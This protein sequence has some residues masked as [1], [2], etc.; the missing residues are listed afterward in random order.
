MKGT[1]KTSRLLL[2]PYRTTDIDLMAEMFADEVV[3]AFTFLGRQSREG[4]QRVLQDYIQF[5]AE[6][7]YGMFAI[8]EDESDEYIGECGLFVSPL[9]RLALRYSL[10]RTAWGRGYA[11]EA[12]SAVID[13]AFSRIGLNGLI[14]GV[15]PGNSPSLRVME[16]LGFAMERTMTA[17]G[18]E[19]HLFSLAR[20]QWRKNPLEKRPL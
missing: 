17:G 6:R 5:F 15:K 4:T 16:K 14:A 1:M 3:T 19:F 11:V 2:R 12:S 18:T 9:G 7:E 8:V 10:R 20:D 13:D